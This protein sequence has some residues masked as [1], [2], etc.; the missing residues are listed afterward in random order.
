MIYTTCIMAY[1]AF[2]YRS[3]ARVQ[4]LIAA[5]LTGLAIFITVCAVSDTVSWRVDD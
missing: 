2:S 1:A 4:A 5:A 3:S